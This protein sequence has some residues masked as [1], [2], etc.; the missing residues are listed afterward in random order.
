VAVVAGSAV[1][2]SSSVQESSSSVEVLVAVASIAVVEVASG[3]VVMVDSSEVLL[4]VL[5]VEGSA[6]LVSSSVQ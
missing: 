5:V 3:P 4:D 2:V 6:V 1:L